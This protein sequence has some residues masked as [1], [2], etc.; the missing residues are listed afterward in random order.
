MR[1]LLRRYLPPALGITALYLLNRFCLIPATAGTL[2]RLLAW[3]GADFLAGGAMVL[4]LQGAREL[5][6]QPP[7]RRWWAVLD[8]LLLCGLFWEVVTPLYLPRSVGDPGDVAAVV[9]GGM[10]LFL[11]LRRQTSVGSSAEL[12]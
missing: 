5:S 7:E 12:P 2:H 3:H 11:G 1:A 9:F 6:G 8:F 10:G 4:V